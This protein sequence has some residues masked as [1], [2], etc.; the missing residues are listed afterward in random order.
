M[1]QLKDSLKIQAKTGHQKLH[2]LK[3][4]KGLVFLRDRLLDITR[5]NIDRKETANGI[6]I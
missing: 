1:T 3:R 4:S 6:G 5:E 2:P